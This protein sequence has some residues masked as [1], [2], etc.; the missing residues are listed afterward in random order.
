[1]TE[2][3]IGRQPIFN[4]SLE[5]IGYELFY[6][7]P[8]S[9]DRSVITDGD[10]ATMHVLF[11]AFSMI[12]FEN[13]VGQGIGFVNV[14][15]NFI[16]GKY[17]IPFPPEKLAL[18]VLE[19]VK[20]TP[21]LVDALGK[22]WSQ[23]YMIALDDV[24]DIARVMPLL[25]VARI[26]KLDLPQINPN[27]LAPM[28]DYLRQLD[29]KLVAEKVETMAEFE[30]CHKLGFDFFQGYFLFK[31]NVVRTQ[32]I[33]SSK[34]VIIHAM[35][36]INDPMATFRELEDYISR[37][38][39]ITYK[40]LRVVNSAYYA[41]HI[42]IRTIGQAV[43]MMGMER[44]RGWLTLLLITS[45]QHKPHELTVTAITRAKFCE[46]LAQASK[47]DSQHSGIYFVVGLFSVL[48]A[49]MDMPLVKALQG[50]PLSDE[51]MEALLFYKGAPGVVLKA[52]MAYERGDLNKVL[53]LNIAPE[54]VVE[55]YVTTL[56]WVNVQ[57]EVIKDVLEDDKAER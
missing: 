12:G 50:L 39:S 42:T 24:V 25:H 49:F 18:E 16:N 45:S 4:R 3:L 57:M 34:A 54:A 6:R 52:V 10:K 11:N 7:T 33:D 32:A 29:V 23:G 41:N 20:I 28:V 5:V 19:S 53:E 27:D 22:L 51:I 44:L 40:L 17:P 46:M 37:D 36:V 8:L 43:S 26:I 47:V 21:Q 2:L 56:K 9:P 1:M 30:M 55:A 38:V 48:N 35:S 13:L 15:D 31:P 14:T